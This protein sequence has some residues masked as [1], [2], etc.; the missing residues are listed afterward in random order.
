MTPRENRIADEWS[1][2]HD[3]PASM[4]SDSAGRF[5]AMAA[6]IHSLTGRRVVGP[7]FPVR[8][9]PGDSRTLHVSLLSAPPGCVLVVDAG[10]FVDR[11]VWGEVLTHSARTA[12]VVGAVIDG[13][14]RDIAAIREMDFPLFA[15]GTAPA[16]PHKA[17]GGTVG[18]P[19]SCGGVIVGPGDLIIGDDDGVAVAR[20]AD[21]ENL[22]C[23]VN[24]RMQLERGWITRISSGEPSAVVLGLAEVSTEKER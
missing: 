3:I 13:A 4:L 16:G 22:Y 8:T 24:Q 12:H 6:A 20:A 11:A 9:M 18:E 21:L 2:W 17:G 1:R 15:R 19:I 23:A 14:V 5:G 10:G 7:A